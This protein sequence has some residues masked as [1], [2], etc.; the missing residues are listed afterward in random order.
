MRAT[1]TQFQP[2]RGVSSLQEQINRLFNETFERG[3]DEVNLTTWARQS[4]FSR[5]SIP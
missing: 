1:L 4:T 3:T 2:F 5:P